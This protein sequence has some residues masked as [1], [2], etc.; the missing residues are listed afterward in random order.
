MKQKFNKRK[1]D[2]TTIF[3]DYLQQ[4]KLNEIFKFSHEIKLDQPAKL[5]K[6]F[7][8]N[9]ENSANKSIFVMSN[10][11]TLIDT[12]NKKYSLKNYN[13][14]IFDKNYIQNLK[15]LEDNRLVSSKQNSI[16]LTDPDNV[17]SRIAEFH[18]AEGTVE[19]FDVLQ[20]KLIAIGTSTG[21]LQIYELL[22]FQLL[23]E[24]KISDSKISS[25][26]FLFNN[27]KNINICLT[28]K[29]TFK[30]LRFTNKFK[31]M[32]EFELDDEA[33]AM[34]R[35]EFDKNNKC[36]LPVSTLSTNV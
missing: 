35:L 29:S 33:V 32:V 15:I 10:C 6:S 5:T 28:Y 23:H 13:S 8:L 24:T 20:G 2:E 14:E 19:C 31:G 27:L 26:M 22:E 21:M 17:N 36:F 7:N 18:I 34:N 9:G 3:T 16:K 1:R 4:L 12:F 11:L 25:V 30:I